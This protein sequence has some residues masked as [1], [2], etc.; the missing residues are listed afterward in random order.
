MAFIETFLSQVFGKILANLRESVRKAEFARMAVTREQTENELEDLTR[1]K[2]KC[3][4]WRIHQ[5]VMPQ[6]ILTLIE[7]RAVV[8]RIEKLEAELAKLKKE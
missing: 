4:G 2:L 7:A 8:E 3:G 1:V 6:V 5:G